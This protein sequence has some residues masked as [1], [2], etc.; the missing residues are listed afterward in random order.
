M[1]FDVIIAATGFDALTGSLTRIDIKGKDGMLLRD[2]WEEGVQSYLGLSAHNFPN[3]FFQYGPQAPTVLCN[4]P[5]CA[6]MQGNWVVEAINYC[7]DH[8]VSTMEA[9]V[10]AEQEWRAKVLKLAEASLLPGTKSWYYGDNIP[11]KPREPLLYLGGVPS[12][13][14]EL[15]AVH[16]SGYEGFV[17]AP[18]RAS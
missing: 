11:G 2:R 17:L 5:T 15:N 7:R 3:M 13:H 8:G 12:Y 4:G 10:E 18:A 9:T 16:D 6:E 14:A 1:E